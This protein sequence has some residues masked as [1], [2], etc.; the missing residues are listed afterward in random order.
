MLQLIELGSSLRDI[1]RLLKRSEAELAEEAAFLGVMLPQ[2]GAIA[3]STSTTD[4]SATT[5]TV[6]YAPARHR[7]RNKTA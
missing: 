2:H 3:V 6:H 1:I 7:S 4:S 5:A